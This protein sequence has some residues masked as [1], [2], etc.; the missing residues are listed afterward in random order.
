MSGNLVF[1]SDILYG[2]SDFAFGMSGQPTVSVNVQGTISAGHYTPQISDDGTSWYD[3]S[4]YNPAG[5]E[6]V[7]ITVAGVYR[8]DVNGYQM[9]R[10]HPSVDFAG[11]PQLQYFSYP[12]P[13]I[14][15][16]SEAPVNNDLLALAWQAG[17]YAANSVVLHD[18]VFWVADAATSDEPGPATDWTSYA[19]L[20]AALTYILNLFNAS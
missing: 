7:T 1:K 19:S 16:L 18:G 15:L 14:S 10:L 6:V 17:A 20:A 9:F 3:I 11:T 2:A 12:T 4:V 8:T 5:S 13:M